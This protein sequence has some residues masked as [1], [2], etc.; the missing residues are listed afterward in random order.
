VPSGSDVVWQVDVF[1]AIGVI[2]QP[3]T[4]LY[5]TPVSELS[6][7]TVPVAPALTTALI[8][9]DVP[10]TAMPPGAILEIATLLVVDPEIT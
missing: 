6:I 2:V 7:S 10:K 4:G 1:D 9:T 8:V 5:V 3:L